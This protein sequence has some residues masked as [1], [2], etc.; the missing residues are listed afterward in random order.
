MDQDVYVIFVTVASAFY[1]S[2]WQFWTYVVF[3][4]C[5]IWGCCPY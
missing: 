1:F 5:G 2:W 4:R 3:I